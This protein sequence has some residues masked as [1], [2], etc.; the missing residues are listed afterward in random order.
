MHDVTIRLLGTNGWYATKT[1][2]TLCILI[3]TQNTTIILDAGDG[4]HKIPDLIPDIQSPVHLFLSHLH[5]DHIVGLHTLARCSFP[6]GLTIYGPPGTGDVLSRF[7][8]RPFTIP[9][10][11][12][13]YPVQIRELPPGES[14]L[15]FPVT[16]GYL[17]H[18]QPVYGYRFD[19]GPIIT[20]CTDTGLCNTILT[21]A[22]GADLLISECSNLPGSIQ[23]DGPHLNPE[24]AIRYAELAKAKQ[25]LLVHFA[26]DLYTTLEQRYQIKTIKTRIPTLIIGEDDLEIILSCLH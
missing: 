19:L 7:I 5:L 6:G 4:I 22:A 13:S 10:A 12:L 18:T 16:T 9:I 17:N 23:E 21:L 8:D 1:G 25:L 2:N 20:F 14:R 11:D 26:A 15:P 3:T 24:S